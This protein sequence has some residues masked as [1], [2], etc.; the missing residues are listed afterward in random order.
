MIFVRYILTKNEVMKKHI[1]SC[2]LL[3]GVYVVAVAQPSASEGSIEFQKGYKPAAVIEYPYEQEVVEKAVK[4][5]MVKKG[6]KE[7][8]IKGF[9]VF[10]GARMTPTD[11]EL[12]DLYFKVERKSRKESNLSR[13][14]LIVGRPSENVALRTTGDNYRIVDGRDFLNTMVPSVEAFQLEVSI[15]QQGEIVQK[16]EKKLKSLEEDQK[17]LEKKIRN[18]EEKLAQNKRDQEAQTAEVAKQRTVKEAMEAR[19]IVAN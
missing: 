12:A 18:F 9:Q 11:G 16:A 19:R 2:I 17:D 10:R 1:L 14:H 3:V 5:Y 15:T 13:V 8:R 4:D 6:L 7:E